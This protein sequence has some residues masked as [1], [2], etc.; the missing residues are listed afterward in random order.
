MQIQTNKAGELEIKTKKAV[1]TF[2]SVTKVNGVELEGTGEYEIG[3]VA[4]E[5]IDDDIYIFKAEDILFGSI[6]F[7]NKISKEN[8][9]KLSNAE[10]LIVRLDGEIEQAV[11]QVNQIEPNIAVYIGSSEAKEKLSKTSSDF[12]SAEL[13]KITKADISEQKA[14][15]IEIHPVTQG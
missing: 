12:E 10:I 3:A 14:Y 7:K 4:I 2:D 6:N 13:I 1:I 15:F 9:E 5:G 8:A 11:D